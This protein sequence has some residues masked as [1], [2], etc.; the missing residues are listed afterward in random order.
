MAE[1]KNSLLFF[2]LKLQASGLNIP[3]ISIEAYNQIINAANGISRILNQLMD[4]T[5]LLLSNYKEDEIIEAI[6]ME[7]INE[8]SI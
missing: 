1:S 4:K 3:I 7:A 2:A 6:A 5:L 8:V